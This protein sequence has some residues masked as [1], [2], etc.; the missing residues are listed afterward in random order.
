MR[1]YRILALCL[2]WLLPAAAGPA[3]AA[4]TKGVIPWYEVEILLFARNGATAGQEQTWPE[5]PGTPD[6][7]GAW[8]VSEAPY[9]Q[10]NYQLLPR[11][12]WRLDREARTLK[13]KG[14][15]QPLIHRAWRQPVLSRKRAHPVHLRSRQT[16]ADGTPEMEG[17]VRVSVARYLH[18][19][20]DFLLRRPPL[21]GMEEKA[22]QTFTPGTVRD[23]RFTAHRRMRSGELHYIDHPLMGALVLITPVEQAEKAA[24]SGD[25]A[26]DG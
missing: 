22:G 19:D 8:Q 9:R 10:G 16:T 6:W 23:Y 17:L 11:A 1:P 7:E 15:F 21:P 26:G 12:R 4:G 13:R 14:G 5:D 20:L 24:D 3:G 2:C 25:E 18:L